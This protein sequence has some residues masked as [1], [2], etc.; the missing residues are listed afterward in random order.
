MEQAVKPEGPPGFES[1]TIVF[2]GFSGQTG[3]LA[4]DSP[5]LSKGS[6]NVHASQAL[7]LK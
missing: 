2:L 7:S 4:F 1:I 6:C 3:L 5:V